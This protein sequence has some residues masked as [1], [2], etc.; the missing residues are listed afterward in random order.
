MSNPA[1]SS[2]YTQIGAFGRDDNYVPITQNGLL[3]T[4]TQTLT[5]NGAT[6]NVPIFSITGT[7]LINALYGVVTTVLGANNTAAYWRLNDGTN[8]SSITVST[9]TTLSAA[10]VGSTIVKKDVAANALVLLSSSQERVSEPT[11]LETLYFSPFVAVQKTAGVATN[12]EFVY[13]TS[14]TPTS[15]VITFYCGWVPLSSGARVAPL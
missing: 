2:T 7:V 6:A 4:D 14:D 8:Q 12:I 15:G 11:T 13:T 9:G 1:A 10:P 5:A 3:T